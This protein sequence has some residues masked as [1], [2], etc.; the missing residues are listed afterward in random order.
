MT[1]IGELPLSHIARQTKR[2]RVKVSLRFVAIGKSLDRLRHVTH[3]SLTNR[4]HA[5][6]MLS[7]VNF[8]FRFEFKSFSWMWSLWMYAS[9]PCL[10]LMAFL[11]AVTL[12][13]RYTLPRKSSHRRRHFDAVR[14]VKLPR[15]NSAVNIYASGPF[16]FNSFRKLFGFHYYDATACKARTRIRPQASFI[17]KLVLMAFPSTHE[18]AFLIQH[19]HDVFLTASLQSFTAGQLSVENSTR[20][21]VRLRFCLPWMSYN[22][23]CRKRFKHANLS[24]PLMMFII[25]NLYNNSR[26]SI[27]RIVRLRGRME[28]FNVVSWKSSMIQCDVMWVSKNQSKRNKPGGRKSLIKIQCS[29]EWSVLCVDSHYSCKTLR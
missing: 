3:I 9:E 4:R 23:G 11:A 12:N 10:I 22:S 7:F 20:I 15:H 5:R 17:I 14:F 29:I 24:S 28:M 26:L 6:N 25:I 2:Q 13:Y 27:P 1:V 8:V 16:N 19:K 18:A 21:S